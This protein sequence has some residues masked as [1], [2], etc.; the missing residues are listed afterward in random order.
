M[1]DADVNAYLASST[2]KKTLKLFKLISFVLVRLPYWMQPGSSQPGKLGKVDQ[3][4]R[5]LE[6][7]NGSAIT[8]EHGQMATG[9]GRGDSP[10]VAHLSELAEFSDMDEL[11]DSS[12]LRGMHPSPRAVRSFPLREIANSTELYTSSVWCQSRVSR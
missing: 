5:L 7:F 4:G 11:V 12:L 6:F 2:D 8:M 10:N 3:A 9:M 1:F